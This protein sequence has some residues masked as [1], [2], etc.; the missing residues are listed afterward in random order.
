MRPAERLPGIA[1]VVLDREAAPPTAV[2]TGEL[3]SSSIAATVLDPI[4]SIESIVRSRWA[5]GVTSVV[6]S[7]A[8]ASLHSFGGPDRATPYTPERPPMLATILP[9]PE[10]IAAIAPPVPATEPEPIAARPRRT[11]D[12]PADAIDPPATPTPASS[13][14]SDAEPAAADPAPAPAMVTASADA[15]NSPDTFEVPSGTATTATGGATSSTGTGTG[16]GTGQSTANASASSATTSRSGGPAVHPAR[17][18]ARMRCSEPEASRTAGIDSPSVI[19]ELTVEA[20]GT[21]S[22]ATVVDDPGYGLGAAAR[23]CALRER[24]S[25]A[26]D[27][28]GRPVASVARYRI[29]FGD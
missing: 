6:A 3:A 23:G 22:R 15:T 7:A 10:P 28:D 20:D 16:A 14:E 29:R 11:D 1:G 18:R 24:L 12:A 13:P 19:V 5:F 27:E 21:V 25:P 17:P 26:R 8:L 2:V 4:A 9:D